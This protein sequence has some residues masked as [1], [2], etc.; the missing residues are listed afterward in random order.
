[1]VNRSQQSILVVD[2]SPLAREMVVRMLSS[3][4]IEVM[5]AE[6]GEEAINVF[7]DHDFALI[8]MDVAMGGI[9]GLET[10]TEIR[11]LDHSNSDVPIIFITAS[12][13]ETSNI[14]DGYEA[15][16]VDYLLK[17][18]DHI[19]L[20]SKV[21]V[22]CR[23]NEQRTVI[24]DQLS[25]IQTKN[26]ELEKH[27]AEIKVLRGFVPICA[28]CKNIRDDAGYWQSIEEYVSENSEAEFSH[29]ICP[30]CSEKL[31]PGLAI[32]RQKTK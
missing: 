8:L 11:K 30:G 7:P 17:P 21:S 31:Y 18:V 25:E 9:S 14:F 28:S 6:S 15:G 24:A 5:T 23:L 32:N 2:D 26:A 13:T 12:N 4:D 16:G 27:I 29:S 19:A 22:F 10:A 1:M 20:R 3:L